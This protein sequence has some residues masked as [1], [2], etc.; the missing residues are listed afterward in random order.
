MFFLS[1]H[2]GR[3]EFGMTHRREITHK[4][5]ANVVVQEKNKFTR[6]I[7]LALF[8]GEIGARLKG[9]KK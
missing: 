1:L 8:E 7:S 3:L 5:N 9:A 2:G 4:G 6:K